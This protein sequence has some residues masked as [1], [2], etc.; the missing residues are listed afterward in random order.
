MSVK[1]RRE[2]DGGIRTELG[3]EVVWD[4]VGRK[5]VGGLTS[6]SSSIEV[7]ESRREPML[8]FFHSSLCCGRPFAS[9]DFQE[10]SS[11]TLPSCFVVVLDSG[12]SGVAR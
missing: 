1:V 3:F 6:E 4:L 5:K 8:T 11:C 2:E 7:N 9:E 12:P 10:L